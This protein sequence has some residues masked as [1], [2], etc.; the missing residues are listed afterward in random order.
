MKMVVGIYQLPESGAYK[1]IPLGKKYSA[2]STTNPYDMFPI[3]PSPYG[4]AVMENG[5]IIN[6]T[7]LDIL[8]GIEEAAKEKAPA[9]YL[10][11]DG[12][13]HLGTRKDMRALKKKEAMSAKDANNLKELVKTFGGKTSPILEQL[14]EN[15]GIVSV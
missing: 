1:G 12:V 14:A 2:I 5:T 8:T 10:D 4:M 3:S 15:S 9:T 7:V 13:Y 11:K 6:K